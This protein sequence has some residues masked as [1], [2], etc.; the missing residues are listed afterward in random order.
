[1]LD[2]HDVG[3]I[4]IN[5]NIEACEGLGEPAQDKISIKK[6]YQ[7]FMFCESCNSQWKSFVAS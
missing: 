4:R 5:I 6:K 7:I 1:M 2:A 3:K